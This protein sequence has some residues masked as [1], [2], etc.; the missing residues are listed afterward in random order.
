MCILSAQSEVKQALPHTA[1]AVL[2]CA[3]L[4]VCFGWLLILVSEY[5]ILKTQT[6]SEGN[7]ETLLQWAPQ[8]RFIPSLKR[9]KYPQIS[10]L[11]C[12]AFCTIKIIQAGKHF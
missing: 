2:H 11:E 12:L 7:A 4:K 1:D 9:Q 6:L 3:I 8:R 5:L 10:L